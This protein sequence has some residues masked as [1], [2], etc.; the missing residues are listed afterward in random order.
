MLALAAATCKESLHVHSPG[1]TCV[2][3]ATYAFNA[4][5]QCGGALK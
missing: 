4:Q 2:T 3:E 1:Q 5:V